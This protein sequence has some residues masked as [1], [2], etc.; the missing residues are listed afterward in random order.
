MTNP[1]QTQWPELNAALDASVPLTRGTLGLIGGVTHS[2]KTTLLTSFFYHICTT[3]KP[4]I[5]ESKKTP[6][7]LYITTEESA[8]HLVERLMDYAC[9]QRDL[10]RPTP[11]RDLEHDDLEFLTSVLNEQGYE[12]EVLILPPNFP[13]TVGNLCSVIAGYNTDETEVHAVFVDGVDTL[14]VLSDDDHVLA[15]QSLKSYVRKENILL[16]GTHLLATA[17][18]QDKLE[19]LPGREFLKK[20]YD[21]SYWSSGGEQLAHV[22]DLE[23][24]IDRH[25]HDSGMDILCGSHKYSLTALPDNCLITIERP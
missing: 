12:T 15:L 25:I 24:M 10:P 14:D 5:S 1:Y 2:Y 13:R 16:L 6:K 17:E 19:S 21:G 23:I 11:D 3:N 18:I 9:V 7:V 20:A 8:G 22:V 4:V